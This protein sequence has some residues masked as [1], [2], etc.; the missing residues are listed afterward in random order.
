MLKRV[1]S[2]SAPFLTHTPQVPSPPGTTEALRVRVVVRVRP[3]TVKKK[4]PSNTRA[5]SGARRG[6][7]RVEGWRG[8]RVEGRVEGWRGWKGGGVEGRTRGV[9]R[10]EGWRGGQGRVG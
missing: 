5:M 1:M 3:C 2:T 9:G 8:W 10:V 6:V 7:G 4:A